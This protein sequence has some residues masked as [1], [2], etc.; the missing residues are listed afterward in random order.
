MAAS[1]AKAAT[2]A[3]RADLNHH[4]AVADGPDGALPSDELTTL[5]KCSQCTG[6]K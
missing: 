1:K 2:V 6:R 3:L 5:P 4:P